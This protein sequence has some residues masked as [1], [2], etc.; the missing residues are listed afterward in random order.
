MRAAVTPQVVQGWLLSH[1]EYLVIWQM[2][3]QKKDIS[4]VIYNLLER[5]VYV[6]CGI[7]PEFD[8]NI[9]LVCHPDKVLCHVFNARGNFST[10]YHY[11]IKR[12]SL[13]FCIIF[14]EPR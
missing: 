7:K 6:T 12:Y 14:L 11:L 9:I 8:Y 10:Y 4:R 1:P 3:C 2:L 5:F 13:S